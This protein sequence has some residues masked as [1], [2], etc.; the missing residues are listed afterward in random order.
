MENNLQFPSTHLSCATT[1]QEFENTDKEMEDIEDIPDFEIPENGQDQLAIGDFNF[2]F[3]EDDC[4]WGTG[5]KVAVCIRTDDFD[6]AIDSNL[7]LERSRYGKGIVK[8]FFSCDYTYPQ[9]VPNKE[10]IFSN[11]SSGQPKYLPFQIFGT[12]RLNFYGKVT[13]LDGWL[14]ICGFLKDF[15]DDPALSNRSWPIRN[16]HL[17]Q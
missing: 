4:Y 9:G 16:V 17:I 1:S 3:D 15:S 7:L 12:N 10:T 5:G 14:S 13:F 11:G 8:I 2:T 6:R